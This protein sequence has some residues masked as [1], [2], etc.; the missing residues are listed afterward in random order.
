MKTVV[1][2]GASAGLGRAIAEA[3]AAR[4][5]QV[6]LLARDR[7]RLDIAA[8][9]VAAAGG[10]AIA[11]PTDVAE[12]AEVEA[13]ADRVESEL[14]PIDVWVN[15]AMVA[16]FGQFR[17]VAPEE[18]RRVTDVSYHGYV[19]GTRAALARMVPRNCGTVVQV[20]SALAYR[21][22]PLQ[23]AYCGAKHAIQGFT[24]SVRCELLHDGSDVHITMVQMPALN[25]PQFDWA[26][27]RMPRRPQP[28]PPI[29]EP[30]VG[31]KA[32]VLASDGR[33]REYWVTW[34]TIRA[35][36]GNRVLPGVLDRMLA[37]VGEDSQ[38]TRQ[39]A[40]PSAPTNLWKPVPGPRGPHGRFGGES[41]R[42]SFEVDLVQL[43][44]RV[45]VRTKLSS[46]ADRV[47]WRVASVLARTMS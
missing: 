7:D 8:D 33:R 38:L 42:G 19:N 32:V 6:A 27:N 37:I 11:I 16:V 30:E 25:T 31:A 28:V 12:F 29:Y 3:F 40:D 23:S 15:N 26:V 36:L 44:D 5:D 34:P 18:F 46:M 10:R 24:E 20:G 4:G 43:R 1:V 21:G 17:D 35:V 9:A 2:T 22:I 13:A 14:G 39:P 45:A 41:R 47:A